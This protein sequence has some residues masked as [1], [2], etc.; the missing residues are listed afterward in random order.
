MFADSAR[1]VSFSRLYINVTGRRQRGPT[2][3]APVAITAPRQ[4]FQRVGLIS[5]MVRLALRLLVSAGSLY[6]VRA[7]CPD[8][9][10]LPTAGA[11]RR[12]L[13]IRVVAWPIKSP[14]SGVTF[15]IASRR[16]G[17]FT[18]ELIR[19]RSGGFDSPRLTA[20]ARGDDGRRRP[21]QI[22][23]APGRMFTPVNYGTSIT[24][25]DLRAVNEKNCQ[26]ATLSR[27]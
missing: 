2:P 24:E 7:R 11:N 22:A 17:D 23:F 16:K 27:A 4:T 5:L 13:S 12:R 10:V 21:D 9:S 15:T 18:S 6:L 20:D 14:D 3:S 25:L 8:P 26:T 1:S 19:D